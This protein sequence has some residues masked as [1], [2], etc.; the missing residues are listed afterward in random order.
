MPLHPVG[1]KPHHSL[2][3]LPGLVRLSDPPPAFDLQGGQPAPAVVEG[4]DALEVAQV[5]KLPVLLRSVADDGDLAGT[6]AL[7]DRRE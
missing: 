6:V 7:G 5:Q 1:D 4:V 3:W 2:P